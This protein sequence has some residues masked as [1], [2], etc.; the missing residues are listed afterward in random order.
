MLFC[1]RGI[2]NPYAKQN[3]NYILILVFIFLS[4]EVF[5]TSMFII[6]TNYSMHLTG[7]KDRIDQVFLNVQCS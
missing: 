6:I 1:H 2:T 5:I 3:Q 4:Y 7:L